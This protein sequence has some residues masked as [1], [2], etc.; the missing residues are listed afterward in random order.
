MNRN[1]WNFTLECAERYY[2]QELKLYESRNL[3]D[4]WWDAFDFFLGHACY[5]GRRDS[6]SD[7]VYLR[8]KE[9]LLPLFGN[10]DRDRGYETIR[11]EGWKPIE[12][13]LK[14]RIG[15]GMVGKARD[16]EMILSALNRIDSYPC[17]NIV[18]YSIQKIENG[19][20]QEHYRE[21]QHQE[22][23]NGIVQVGPKVASFYLRDIVSLFSLENSVDGDSAFCLQP[24]DVW[25]R[26]IAE[27]LEIVDEDAEVEA[28]QKEIVRKCGESGISA[29]RFNQGVWYAGS[30][31]LDLL[32]E[33][34]SKHSLRG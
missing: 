22:S 3:R 24:V 26:R 7:K 25:V 13:Q 4:N 31:S 30:Y 18:N 20:V 34:A 27:R 33:F 9:I 6:L 5:Q 1:L 28:I 8:A 14:N 11:R 2:A 17:R 16:I 10:S 29:F 15:K 19:L 12:D 23:V 32:I 21:L